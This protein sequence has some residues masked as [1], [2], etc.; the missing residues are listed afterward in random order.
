MAV[1]LGAGSWYLNPKEIVMST[2]DLRFTD[3]AATS[4]CSNVHSKVQ[5][6]DAFENIMPWLSSVGSAVSAGDYDN[7]GLVDFYVTN[8]EQNSSN[9][10]FHNLGDGKFDDVALKA[11]VADCNR[12]G[13][14]MDAIFFDYDNDG[15]QDLYV[16]KWSA[17]YILYENQGDGTFKNITQR[18]GVGFWGNANGAIAFDYD[19]DGW[20]DIFV[21]NYFADSV[22]SESTGKRERNDL[23]HPVTTKIMHTTFTHAVNGGRNV[24]YKNMHDGTFKDITYETGLGHTGWSL[25]AGSGDLNNDGWPDLYVAN[26]FGADELYYNTGASEYP[27]KFRLAIDPDGHPGI[28][29]DWWKGMNVDIADVDGNGRMDIYITNILARRYK[30]D[31]GNMLW[32][33]YPDPSKIG[34]CKFVNISSAA[35]TNDGGW[36]WG[37]KFC[38]FNNDGLLDIFALNGFTTGTDPNKTYWYQLQE[39]VTQTKNNAAD[40]KVWPQMGDRDL[41]GYEPSRLFIQLAAGSVIPPKKKSQQLY[42]NGKYPEPPHFVESATSCGITDVY[43]GRGV[44]LADFDN[45]G[46]IDMYVANQGAQNCFYRNEL[47]SKEQPTRKGEHWLGLSL[48]GNPQLVRTLGERS[49]ASSRDASGTRVEI[50]S[51]GNRY[52]REVTYCN[53]F[54]S[55]SEKRII[56]GLGSA[57]SIDSLVVNWQSGRKEVFKGMDFPVDKYHTIKEAQGRAD[58]AVRLTT[59]L[60][61][62]P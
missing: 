31:E 25:D 12:E 20:L 34:G 49:F 57:T 21:A 3:I 1:L 36:G 23:W 43:N 13:A 32:L 39:M 45:D 44:A 35:G 29:N 62:K 22:E 27:P 15:D 16:V 18:A 17:P 7:D 4:G 54:A 61:E 30:T 5:L 40:T 9:R 2:A 38:D 50:W 48:V 11:G 52:V 26:D 19:R 53:G 42:N 55:Q 8:S 46:D 59:Q 28:G 24:L 10:L 56:V 60:V 14:S 58:I 6:S 47:Y 51:K 33:N 41:S 37:G